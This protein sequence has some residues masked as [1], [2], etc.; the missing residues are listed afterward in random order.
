MSGHQ[1]RHL[2]GASRPGAWAA[3]AAQVGGHW[4]DTG[5]TLGGH[6]E[7]TGGTLEERLSG[8]AA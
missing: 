2:G 8:T 7:D 5:R 4:E 1:A 3:Q 6:W